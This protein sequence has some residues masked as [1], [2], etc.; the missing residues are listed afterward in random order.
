VT[1]TAARFAGESSL[2]VAP[3]PLAASAATEAASDDA[4]KQAMKSV[5]CFRSILS[6][7]VRRLRE[8][9]NRTMS[10]D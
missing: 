4:S 6:P 1:F 7:S 10:R 9:R 2:I 8:H 3:A 5:R